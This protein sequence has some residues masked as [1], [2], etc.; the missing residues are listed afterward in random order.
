[1]RFVGEKENAVDKKGLILIGVFCLIVIVSFVFYSCSGDSDGVSDSGNNATSMQG[2]VDQKVYLFSE[3][4]GSAHWEVIQQPE[5]SQIELINPNDPNPYFVPGAPGQHLLRLTVRNNDVVSYES[6]ITVDV[7]YPPNTLVDV[8]MRV[9]KPKLDRNMNAADDED[10]DYGITVGEN[11]YWADVGSDQSAIGFQA[12]LLSRDDLSYIDDAFFNIIDEESL[13]K[14]YNTLNGWQKKYNVYGLPGKLPNPDADPPLPFPEAVLLLQSLMRPFDGGLDIK[15]FLDAIDL[16]GNPSRLPMLTTDQFGMIGVNEGNAV[17]YDSEFSSHGCGPQSVKGKFFV[18][19]HGNWNFTDTA[20]V[21]FST[22]AGEE[23]DTFVLGAYNGQDKLEIKADLQGGAGGFQV[24]CLN[25]WTLDLVSCETFVTNKG[26]NEVDTEQM[27]ELEVHLQTVSPKGELLIALSSIGNA[28]I[29]SNSIFFSNTQKIVQLKGGSPNAIINTLL[30]ENAGYSI[31][32]MGGSLPE[33]YPYLKP[34]STTIEAKSDSNAA[35]DPLGKLNSHLRRDAI[36]AF[37]PKPSISGPFGNTD[38]LFPPNSDFHDVFWNESKDWPFPDQT[39]DDQVRAFQALSDYIAADAKYRKHKD[40]VC[41][42]IRNLYTYDWG[43][44]G[45]P[46]TIES[47]VYEKIP[48]NDAFSKE[49]FTSIQDKL[50]HE[51]LLLSK[52]YDFFI[53]DLQNQFYAQLFGESASSIE[54]LYTKLLGKLKL[55][56]DEEQNKSMSIFKCITCF[57]GMAS[58]LE[59]TLK[60]IYEVSHILTES[61]EVFIDQPTE[62]NQ[63]P[64]VTLNETASDLWTTFGKKMHDDYFILEYTFCVLVGNYAKME[65]VANKRENLEQGWIWDLE[66]VNKLVDKSK[67]AFNAFFLQTLLPVAYSI[68]IMP[69]VLYQTPHD[70]CWCECMHSSCSFHPHRPPT[71]PEAATYCQHGENPAVFNLY[72]LVHK[73]HS[74][75]Y[76]DDSYLLNDVAGVFDKDYLFTRWPFHRDTRRGWDHKPCNLHQW[77][78][79]YDAHA[80]GECCAND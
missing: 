23:N 80:D 49:T 25:K 10:L 4:S 79:N 29:N 24:C 58:L 7:K 77:E 18:N 21:R 62:N 63:D 17:R 71:P 11:T 72:S 35:S 32:F 13:N 6:E 66:K 74:S 5:V 37:F 16:W 78:C 1:M 19:N 40:R 48:D 31:I 41:L 36:G 70:F 50:Y 39:Q 46:G 53:N 27:L 54:S 65:Y 51:T 9:T 3:A 44:D 55:E 20:I 38:N 61:A 42:N 60:P 14:M 56:Q 2:Y 69:A 75:H 67:A 22:R 8:K 43:W 73:E 45:V 26:D 76:M 28:C 33:E 15:P 59:E 64:F 34:V 52:L 12:L 30:S 57:L 47:M 68:E